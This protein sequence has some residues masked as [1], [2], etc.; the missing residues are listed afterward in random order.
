MSYNASI[1]WVEKYRP[2]EIEHIVLDPLNKEILENIIKFSYFP[3]LLFYGPPG[4][5]K[6]T[7]ITNLVKEY[8]IKLG[9]NH[10]GLMIHLNAS[11][12]R[13][14]DLIRN[15]I[16]QFV[17]S[18][19]LFHEGMKFVILDEVDYM[20]KS[21]QQALRCL[22][23]KYSSS[24]RFCLICNYISKVDEK[25]QN[26]F[27]KVRF[28][29]LP[30]NHI[31]SFLKNIIKK[32]NIELQDADVHSIQQIYSSDIRSMINYIQSRYDCKKILSENNILKENNWIE[33]YNLFANDNS[34]N[35]ILHHIKN[36]SIKYQMTQKNIIK[37]FLNYIVRKKIH[38]LTPNIILF[39]KNLLHTPHY[40]TDHF[41]NYAVTQLLHLMP[42]D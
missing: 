9:E 33:L 2:Q 21:A 29:N 5:G 13:G 25:L 26:E 11:D 31:I 34:S 41:I 3:N 6:T 24:V 40:K 19:S 4:T 16:Q 32:E 42:K 23:M 15:Q 28:N 14:I 1:P 12:E 22:I 38:I 37:D 36:M 17:N 10:K 18:K 8:Q 7:T 30:Q 27:L 20:T 39:I 35:N